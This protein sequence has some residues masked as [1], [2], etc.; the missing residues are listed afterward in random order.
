MDESYP[1]LGRDSGEPSPLRQQQQ[2]QPDHGSSPGI[3]SGVPKLHHPIWITDHGHG[4]R[5]TWSG[6]H[7]SSQLS[8][9]HATTT[10]AVTAHAAATTAGVTTNTPTNT[11]RSR[12][13]APHRRAAKRRA[14]IGVVSRSAAGASK[15]DLKEAEL[16][17]RKAR[18][19]LQRASLPAFPC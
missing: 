8:R 7:P 1:S 4:R 16:E 2:Q 13:P 12:H 15:Q 6:R 3:Q 17:M 10:P 18:R 5:H 14:D 9:R 19:A 11:P